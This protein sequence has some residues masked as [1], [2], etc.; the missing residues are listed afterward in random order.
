MGGGVILHT[1]NGGG[2]WSRQNSPPTP[3]LWAVHFADAKHGWAVGKEGTTLHTNNG[4]QIWREQSSS[5]EESL[6][7][8]Y[9]VNPQTGWVVGTGGLILHTTD[10]GAKLEAP[11]KWHI[12]NLAWRCISGSQARL[13][14]W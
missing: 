7:A 2:S 10:G 14:D 5:T 3:H 11:E 8:V 13:G 6:L 1:N 12:E 9:F 4:G